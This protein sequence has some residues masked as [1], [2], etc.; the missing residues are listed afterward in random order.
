M[1]ERQS[2]GDKYK[3]ILSEPTMNPS[4]LHIGVARPHWVKYTLSFARHPERNH[5]DYGPVMWNCGLFVVVIMNKLKK[6]A[7]HAICPWF[8]T[9]RVTL[10]VLQAICIP[11]R[12]H[13][14]SV[15]ASEFIGNSSVCFTVCSGVHQSNTN[16]PLLAQVCGGKYGLVIWKVTSTV[17]PVIYTLRQK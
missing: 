5:A 8:Q 16:V 2:T 17:K 10:E 4:L 1:N 11:L 15:M 6:T 9:L 14:M 13:H 12:G 7:E 3:P